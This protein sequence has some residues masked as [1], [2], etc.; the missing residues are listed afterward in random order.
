VLGYR[1]KLEFAQP[2]MS[3]VTIFK[4]FQMWDFWSKI[5][6]NLATTS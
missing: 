2:R 6:V 3:I 4:E 1:W 5:L